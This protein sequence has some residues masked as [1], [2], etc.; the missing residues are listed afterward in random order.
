MADDSNLS[1]TH[2]NGSAPPITGSIE[3][4][5]D[6]LI[7]FINCERVDLQNGTTLLF[8]TRSDNQLVVTPEVP[9]LLDYCR[10]F[11]TLNEHV[12]VILANIPQLAEQREG[13]AEALKTVWRAG[14]ITT[15]DSI[16]AK[17]SDDLKEQT[18]LAPSRVFIIT[19][20]R[21]AAVERLLESML[22]AGN[23]SRHEQLF[24]IDDS[25]SEEHAANNRE[26]VARFNRSSPKD[27]RY[28]GA[29]QQ[30]QFMD[31][32]I[33]TLP[34]NEQD[35]R[36]LIDRQRW[37]GHKSYGLAR[38]TCLLLSVG[39]RAVIM[40]DD[41]ICIAMNS[42]HKTQGIS[43]GGS[44]R[45][46]DFYASEQSMRAKVDQAEV[47][48]LTGHTQCLGMPISQA[49][50]KLGIATLEPAHV[51]NANAGFLELLNPDSS[52]IITQSGTLGDPGT[53]SEHWFHHL[54][55]E[56]ITRLLNAEGGVN[57]AN[58]SRFHWLGRR[59][60]TFSKMAVM[61]QVTGLDNSQLLPPYFPVFRGED[62]LFGGMVEYLHPSSVVLEYDWC[63]PHH[64]VEVRERPENAA[65]FPAA[66][67]LS[68]FARY[69]TDRT[70]HD[71]SIPLETRINSLAQMLQ[72]LAETSHSGLLA[73]YRSEIAKIRV[74]QAQR[75]GANL[76]ACPE[77]QIV[78][79]EL[80]E[81]AS[82][83]TYNALQIPASLTDI[84]EIPK[85]MSEEQVLT[86]IKILTG[87]YASALRD[88]P[89]IRE[90]SKTITAS[91][92]ADGS[93]TP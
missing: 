90:A 53:S 25:R 9:L 81:N 10:Y 78:W 8:H 21:P 61:S 57:T 30:R 31:E 91:M 39:Y 69:V 45:E 75:A 24:L 28:M 70:R 88:W 77:D 73:M 87:E 60:P 74:G 6:T 76:Q 71:L 23:L 79:R 20:D 85:T 46:A 27:M 64:P 38:T 13:V 4:S 5:E 12:N 52:V 33:N 41:V 26:A 65:P 36:F 37:A 14:L 58:D 50:R 44:T 62:Y 48:P 51:T 67:T 47:E 92:L 89:A 83:E 29:A 86:E 42:P 2:Q 56:S 7:A 16:C 66:A 35:I 84:P 59:C 82:A 40:D 1:H 43:F 15:A 68:L 17:L 80:L 32:L 34:E 72:E 18:S 22:H 49:T 11:R 54:G 19:C 93:F 63:V 55:N 3:I